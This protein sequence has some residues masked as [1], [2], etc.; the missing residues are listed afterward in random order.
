VLS[1]P[2]GYGRSGIPISLRLLMSLTTTRSYVVARVRVGRY[3]RQYG[4]REILES[5]SSMGYR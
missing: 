2:A 3:C 4:L 5:L 1:P